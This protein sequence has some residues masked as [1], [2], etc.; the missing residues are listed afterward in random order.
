MAASGRSALSSV[1]PPSSRANFPPSSGGGAS[2]P[3]RQS[4]ERGYLAG[5]IL[6][7]GARRIESRAAVAAVD[8]ETEAIITA[9]AGGSGVE[10][11]EDEKGDGSSGEEGETLDGY[12]RDEERK[13][14]L[15]GHA[16]EEGGGR[17]EPGTEHQA[18]EGAAA[19][20]AA[21][22]S[23]SGA[24]A[25]AAGGEAKGLEEKGG[26]SK[27]QVGSITVPALPSVFAAEAPPT[28]IP[29]PAP[30]GAVNAAET[31]VAN[32][33][34]GAEDTA[35]A[36]A[37][38]EAPGGDNFD[39]TRRPSL[40]SAAGSITLSSVV[41][42]PRRG[43]GSGGGGRRIGLGVPHAR[44]IRITSGGDGVVGGGGGGGGG[45][46]YEDDDA[47]S[48]YAGSSVTNESVRHEGRISGASS[49]PTRVMGS[50]SG[51]P[52][53]AVCSGLFISSLRVS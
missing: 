36:D 42:A 9:Q 35:D 44:G 33:A 47:E 24:S 19:A 49:R 12:E 26:G 30:K 38:P 39:V 23:I 40:D 5:G 22:V 34:V 45:D 20:S 17:G 8:T 31:R 43:T 4:D 16:G 13:A 7:G 14:L 52:T 27:A 41:S 3:L 21:G 28:P 46:T 6:A 1:V 29:P 50:L 32:E 48:R 51:G 2:P 11:E 18:G 37:G 10:V 15:Q 53:G 25:A